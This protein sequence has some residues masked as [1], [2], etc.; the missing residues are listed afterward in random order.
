[1]MYRINW[2]DF[3]E[4][5]N[6]TQRDVQAM[7]SILI[8][9]FAGTMLI[10]LAIYLLHAVGVYK[11][12][13]SAGVENA[14]LAFIPIVNVL[15]FGQIAEKYVKRD[16][17]KSAKF[18]VILLVLQLV[19]SALAFLMLFFCF[20]GI[21]SMIGTVINAADPAQITPEEILSPLIPVFLLYMPCIGLALALTI[22]RYVALWR[23]FCIFDYSNAT[24][25]TVLCVLFGGLLEAIF[26]FVLRNRQPVFDYR[27]RLNLFTQNIG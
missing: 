19:G 25:F 16:G 20:R 18:G 12:A 22:V 24:L 10:A 14:W 5:L 9:I 1:M 2:S 15:P 11:M 23:I 3:L 7:L 17:T 6:L 4:E 13:K 26:L 21:A 8:A 27:E